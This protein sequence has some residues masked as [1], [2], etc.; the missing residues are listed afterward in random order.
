MAPAWCPLAGVAQAEW[1]SWLLQQWLWVLG[2]SDGGQPVGPAS[3]QLCG[4]RQFTVD[5]GIHA[6]AQELGVM[7]GVAG[8]LLI[9]SNS[10]DDRTFQ[11]HRVTCGDNNFL[12]K[13]SQYY[14][15]TIFTVLFFFF[16]FSI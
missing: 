15:Y 7:T 16:I 11:S 1:R 13:E 9:K 5:L 12:S 3:H 2:S 4:P 6:H 14:L 8:L 10:T